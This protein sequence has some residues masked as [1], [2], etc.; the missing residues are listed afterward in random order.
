[1]TKRCLSFLLAAVLIGTMLSACSSQSTDG[2]TH[3]LVTETT[4][5]HST[6]TT[7]FKLSYSQADSLNPYLSKT[8]N[9]QVVQ[10]LVFDSLFV[11]DGN[12]EAQPSIATSYIYEDAGTLNVTIPSGLEFSN[13]SKLTAGSVVYSFEQAKVSPHWSNMLKGISSATAVSDTVISFKLSYKNPSAHNL[14]TFAVS[15]GETD[16]N[17]LP[18]GSGRYKFK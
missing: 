10:N 13:G 11:L 12:F 8:L 7:G 16:K 3:M 17:G 18:I 15:N 2:N 14:L 5:V 1:M 6:D 4:A 9:N